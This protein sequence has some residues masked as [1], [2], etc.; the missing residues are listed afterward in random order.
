V[1][2]T[3]GSFI[4]PS[5]HIDEPIDPDDYQRTKI[6][7]FG[8]QDTTKAGV[9]SHKWEALS[10]ITGLGNKGIIKEGRRRAKHEKQR[11]D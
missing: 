7:C 9:P 3:V 2:G 1:L 5:P 6:I 11:G 10:V 8:S 4:I